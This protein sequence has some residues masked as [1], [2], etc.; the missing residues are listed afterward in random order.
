ML[1]GVGMDNVLDSPGTF[2]TLV[3]DTFMRVGVCTGMC[4]GNDEC[5]NVYRLCCIVLRSVE[6]V[7]C[8]I[9]SHCNTIRGLRGICNLCESSPMFVSR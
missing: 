3:G 2:F 5:Y 4:T 7:A 9:C 8:S 1:F 6:A